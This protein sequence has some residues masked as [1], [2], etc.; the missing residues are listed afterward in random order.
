LRI[1]SSA[2]LF[3][4]AMLLFWRRTAG[5][6]CEP[7]PSAG[8]L[9]A[10]VCLAVVAAAAHWAERQFAPRNR[11]ALFCETALS[12]SLLAVALSLSLPGT[13]LASLIVFWLI[14]LL[15]EG[16]AWFR[17]T[18]FQP[19][20]TECNT[21]L[22][23][24][25]KKIQPAA[26]LSLPDVESPDSI[27]PEEVTQQFTRST[28]AD[29]TEELAGWLRIPF[30]A[31]QRSGSVHVAFCPPFARTPEL[32][33]EQLDGPEARLK[34]AQILPYGARVDLKLH[35]PAET[36]SSVVLHFAAWLAKEKNE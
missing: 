14:L 8:I 12:L 11:R 7:L 9:V 16:F 33:V 2:L 20:S 6:I 32:S 17:R 10:G 5:A 4:L 13:S 24:S 26:P 34:T 22:L 29:G 23:E 35:T 18:G 3:A 28:A 19:V 25:K 27:P 15:E 1:L 21:V 30:V 31:G 36:S